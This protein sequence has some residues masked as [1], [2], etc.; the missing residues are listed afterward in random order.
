MKWTWY[1]SLNKEAQQ[2]FAQGPGERNGYDVR[3]KYISEAGKNDWHLVVHGVG[4]V[5]TEQ[6]G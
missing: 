2:A 6:K 3:G 5:I 1:A 4:K